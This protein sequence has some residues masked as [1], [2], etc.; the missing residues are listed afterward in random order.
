MHRCGQL[1]GH[2]TLKIRD[3]KYVRNVKN[4]IK[5]YKAQQPKQ[6]KLDVNNG[7]YD[8]LQDEPSTDAT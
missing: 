7:S 2:L 6:N 8:F 1:A 5:F 3:S 4:T